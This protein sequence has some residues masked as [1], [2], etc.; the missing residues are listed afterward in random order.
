M[1]DGPD[2]ALVGDGYAGARDEDQKTTAAPAALRIPE[3][4]VK[5]GIRYFLSIVT[6][7]TFRLVRGVPLING[8]AP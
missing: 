6:S 8:R 7:A 5:L 4:E 2:R 1:L 3:S